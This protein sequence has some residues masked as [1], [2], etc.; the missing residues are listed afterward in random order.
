LG[1]RF[2]IEE[3]AG[4][5]PSYNIAPTQKVAVVLSESQKKLSHAR[6]G[7]IPH[8]AKDASMGSRM[9][10][11]GVETIDQKPAFQE[12]FRNYRC[13]VLANGFYE[14]QNTPAGKQP[15]YIS[16]QDGQ[17]FAFAGIYSRWE[18][19]DGADV[20]SCSIL[21]TEPNHIVKPI[22]HRMPVILRKNR[23]KMW[24]N[25]TPVQ[26]LQKECIRPFPPGKMRAVRVSKQVNTPSNNTPELV[27][28]VQSGLGR[29]R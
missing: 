15:Y 12:A 19:E 14:W 25:D 24:L 29:Y 28:P 10:N 4:Y 18:K 20:L 2:L 11:A 7:L 9:I 26:L 8:W 17:P 21:T 6:W 13:L 22:H 1:N 23:E 16:M 3:L 27:K 5:Q